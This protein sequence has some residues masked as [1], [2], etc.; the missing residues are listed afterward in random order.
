M[1]RR[2]WDSSNKDLSDMK[3]SPQ[4][5]KLKQ[6]ASVKA[7]RAHRTES[8]GAQHKK[9]DILKKKKVNWK[10]WN[11]RESVDFD[12]EIEKFVPVVQVGSF[13]SSSVVNTQSV[14]HD[15]NQHLSGTMQ[16]QKDALRHLK[17][18]IT[19]SIPDNI[20]YAEP[21]NDTTESHE[22]DTDTSALFIKYILEVI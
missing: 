8:P 15:A 6:E 2:E 11:L 14:I 16:A 19:N 3:Y 4:Q 7:T 12:S 1:V 10:D 17:N 21:S 20:E 22:I 9:D 5:R 18:V 13:H